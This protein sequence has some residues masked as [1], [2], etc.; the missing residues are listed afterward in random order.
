MK[1]RALIYITLLSILILPGA[2]VSNAGPSHKPLP[3]LQINIAPTQP[4]V[5]SSQINPGDIVEFKVIAVSFM[6]VQEMRIDVELTGGA[7]L[8][9]GD[10]SWSGPAAKNEEKTFTLTVQAPEKGKGRV[11]ARVTLPPSN[12]TRFSAETEFRLGPEVKNK[13]EQEPV[14]KKDR[15]GR[16][17]IEYR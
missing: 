10:T 17:I 11:R 9:S 7:K 6:D 12:S 1:Q 15:K 2:G 8:L 16:S 14:I 4:G 13:P 3:P 5:T